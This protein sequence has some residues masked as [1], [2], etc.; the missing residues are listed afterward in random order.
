[1]PLAEQLE[2]AIDRAPTPWRGQ[3]QGLG[4]S[5]DQQRA[6]FEAFATFNGQVA[7]PQAGDVAANALPAGGEWNAFID[8]LSGYLNGTSLKR[9]SAEDYAAYSEASTECNWRLPSSYGSLIVALAAGLDIQYGFAVQQIEWDSEHVRLSSEKGSIVAKKAIVTVSTDVL[10]RGVIRFLP[11]LDDILDAAAQLPLGHV[12][13]MFFALAAAE[14]FPDDAHLIGDAHSSDTG[15]YMLRPMGIPVLEGFFGGDWVAE[16][17][18]DDIESL[19]REELRRLL[20]RDFDR[21]IERIAHSSWKD[22]PWFGGS[23]SYARPGQRSARQR[24][25]APIDQR[26]AFAGEACSTTDYSTVHGAWES[27]IAAVEHLFGSTI[28]ERAC[29][30]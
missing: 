13:K 19:A 4:F 11:S 1:V 28:S 12:E 30:Q 16:A 3:Y 21:R 17:N 29:P 7:K 25:A 8:A 14:E 20:G 15:S 27:G 18:S 23:Y 5:V 22:E 2:L 6:A 10:A 9:I 26:L 24:L